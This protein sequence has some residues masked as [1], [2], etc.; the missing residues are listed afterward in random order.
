MAR[1]S[2]VIPAYNEQ[3]R[4]AGTL[5]ACLAYLRKQAYKSEVI[6]VD[7][8]STDRTVEIA[9]SFQAD[10]LVLRVLRQP[11]NLGKG[12]AVRRGCQA[13]I[14]ELVMFMDADHSTRIE[15][16]ERFLPVFDEGYQV[17]A[18]V[19][20]YQ[21]GESRLRR[22]V[23]LGFLMF[24][25][26]FV[27]RKAVVDSQCGFKCFTRRA[28]QQI[29]SRCRTNGGTIDVEIIFLAHILDLGIFFVP[30][31]WNNAP[32]STISIWKCILGDPP[33]MLKVRWREWTGQYEHANTKL[34]VWDEAAAHQGRLE[35]VPSR[36]S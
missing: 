26:L 2:V 11:R 36:N 32:G 1:L 5:E 19:R 29:F 27:F 24:A 14:G 7:D 4:L 23:G 8:G 22:I 10:D 15:E 18:G 12:A 9:E 33:D 25:H 16:I 28:A 6:V 34:P 13:A 3:H 17:V 30:V 20:T 35:S 31:Q 21:E